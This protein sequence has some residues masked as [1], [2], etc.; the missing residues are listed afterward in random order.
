[1]LSYFTVVSLSAPVETSL[2]LSALVRSVPK[3][4]ISTKSSATMRES[5][6][7]SALVSAFARDISAA[8]TSSAAEPAGL[9]LAALATVEAMKIADSTA[10]RVVR[11]MVASPGFRYGL[12][13][14]L[15]GRPRAGSPG[16]RGASTSGVLMARIL[17]MTM[18][19]DDRPESAAR[20]THEA[21][22][23]SL[24]A[25]FSLA[26][27]ISW[28]CWIPRARGLPHHTPPAQVLLL[29]G[30]FSPGLVSLGLTLRARG[31]PGVRALLARVLPVPVAARW[32][33]FALGY[34][35]AVKLAAA[36]L[37]R[38]V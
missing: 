14:S 6:V 23:G 1:M 13:R 27:S 22:G 26:F 17:R 3:R 18:A 31:S 7:V 5:A 21:A 33:A 4:E 16:C 25:S 9:G 38:A 28:A 2:R 36:L 20:R 35:L 37:L 34:L 19:T 10:R 15:R 8:R 11:C 12:P 24:V 29:T 30:V 32:V